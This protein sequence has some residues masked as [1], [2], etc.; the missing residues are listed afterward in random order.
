MIHADAAQAAV[1]AFISR[2]LNAA[3]A[4][5]IVAITP[6]APD[7]EQTVGT[8]KNAI[9]AARATTAGLKIFNA[10]SI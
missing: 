3:T 4:P 2:L 1:H 8:N 9:A 6:L 10:F 7:A 5:L